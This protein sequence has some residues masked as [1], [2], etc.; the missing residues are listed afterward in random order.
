MGLSNLEVTNLVDNR[1]YD[2][3]ARALKDLI[4]EGTAIDKIIDTRYDPHR[5]I[6]VRMLD[7][8][9]EEAARIAL[10]A[11]A[12][13]DTAT[14]TGI[15]ALTLVSQHGFTDV[16]RLLIERGAK[17]NPG[18]KRHDE[19]L[20]AAAKNG[21]A[22]IVDLLLAAGADVNSTNEYGH[23]PLMA[24]AIAG[25]EPIMRTLVAGGADP[26]AKDKFG[27]GVI[28]YAVSNKHDDCAAYL[29]SIGA[30]EA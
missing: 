24:A 25:N 10:A 12:N 11:G 4:A 3:A 5:P 6:W 13:P 27:R 15:C 1:R 28:H 29:T 20:Y 2:E 8:K 14:S 23:T 19:P 22:E 18:N 7:D 21:H 16:V 26:R 9:C 17:V 30:G